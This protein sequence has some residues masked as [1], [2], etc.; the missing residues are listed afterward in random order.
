[1]TESTTSAPAASYPLFYRSP[2]LLRFADH[3][4]FGLRHG[5]DYRFAATATAIPVVASE[6][7]AAGRHYPI[8]FANDG[9]AMPLLVTGVSVDKNLF[10]A[11]D[12]SWA[13]GRYVPG[14]V[15]RYPFIGMTLEGDDA[16][17]LG[18]DSA[19][20][21]ISTDASRDAA[22]PFFDAEGQATERSL[23]AMRLC[24]AYGGDHNRTEAFAKALTEN[25]LLVE[26]TAQMNYAEAGQAVVQGF[27]LVDEVAF[28]ALP[29][30]VVVAFHANGWLDLIVL[31]LASQASWQNLLE[32][33][34]PAS[35]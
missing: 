17:M 3:A 25:G 14:Y 23:A 18:I 34:A 12:G 7:A 10:V 27:R 9:S 33:S 29:A 22:A 32:A 8:V 15:R 6:F 26:R 19:S 16:T 35:P 28:R 30:A 5:E 21:Q 31:H 13:P 4:H 1:M 24:E 20:A 11:D 2:A